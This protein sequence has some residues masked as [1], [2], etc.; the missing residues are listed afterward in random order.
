MND[1]ITPSF[2]M[3]KKV[4]TLVLHSPTNSTWKYVIEYNR[5]WIRGGTICT[6]NIIGYYIVLHTCVGIF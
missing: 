1:V 6:H 3:D 5:V 4:I 2:E